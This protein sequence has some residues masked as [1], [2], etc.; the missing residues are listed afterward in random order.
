MSKQVKVYTTATNPE[1]GETVNLAPGDTPPS[2]ADKVLGDH[3]YQDAEDG[4]PTEPVAGPSQSALSKAQLAELE[5][6]LADT[7]EAEE[8][9]ERGAKVE[10]TRTSGA[11]TVE[12]QAKKR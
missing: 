2:W 11:S 10:Q 5:R 12:Q 9:G 6:Q 4:T 3:V 7:E 8:Q 1:T